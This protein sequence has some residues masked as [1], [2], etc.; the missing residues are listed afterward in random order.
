MSRG[1]QI[2]YK[3]T[4]HSGLDLFT[5]Y[6]NLPMSCLSTVLILVSAAVLI[7]IAASLGYAGAIS[8]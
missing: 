5:S 1:P 2:C 6:P 3:P 4:G 7:F 8:H